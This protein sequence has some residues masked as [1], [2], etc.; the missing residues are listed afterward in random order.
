[1]S[2]QEEDK[3]PDQVVFDETTQRYDASL[4]SYGTNVG[5]PSI[6]T[7]Q[8]KTWKSVGISKVNHMLK[9]KF[10]E[11]QAEYDKMMEEYK[12]NELVYNAEY[13]FEPI[14]GE[15]YHLYQRENGSVFLS[16]IPPANFNYEFIGSFQLTFEKVW[17]KMEE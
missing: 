2:K 8:V 9:Q 3:K 15:V 7:T 4:K 5:A 11:L 6:S 17:K 13:N 12:W 16:V 14:V 10:D 1:M